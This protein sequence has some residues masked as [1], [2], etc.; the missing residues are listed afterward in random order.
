MPPPRQPRPRV[1]IS[2][3]SS[4][5]DKPEKNRSERN[6][7][8]LHPT[9]RFPL[10]EPVVDATSEAFWNAF[11]TRSGERRSVIKSTLVF[12]NP[13]LSRD[14]QDTKIQEGARRKLTPEVPGRNA[15][16]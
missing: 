3:R 4:V 13:A 5:P 10:I 9:P 2:P 15:R 7:L 8:L 11:T 14:R 12:L 16:R 6:A 1:A